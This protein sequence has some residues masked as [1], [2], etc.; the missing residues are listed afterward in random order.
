M[1]VLRPDREAFPLADDREV[2]GL[3]QLGHEEARADC[4]RDAAGDVD[5][6]ARADGQPVQRAEQGV[7]VLLLDPLEVALPWDRLAQADPHLRL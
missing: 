3:L 2:G 4:V 6:V 5:D 7:A 1:A